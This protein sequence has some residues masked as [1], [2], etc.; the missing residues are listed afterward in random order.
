MIP[1]REILQSG[2]RKA[3]KEEDEFFNLNQGEV[4]FLDR[5][6]YADNKPLCLS[7]T[8]IPMNLFFKID[9]IDFTKNS[10][11]KIIEEN[12]DFKITSSKLGIKAISSD[13]YLSAKLHISKNSPLLLSSGITFAYK[14][15]KTYPIE[16]FKS[17]YFTDVFEYSLI[18]HR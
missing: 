15:K 11:Y 6:I 13:E 4:F 7:T 16:M 12:Y 9:T 18:Q 8:V 2:V 10:L 3:T 1:S 14:L 5:M 17:Y